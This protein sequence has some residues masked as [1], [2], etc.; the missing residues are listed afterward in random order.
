MAYD[1]DATEKNEEISVAKQY[2]VTNNQYFNEIYKEALETGL[3]DEKAH[4]KDNDYNYIY[5]CDDAYF[6]KIC[7]FGTMGAV[8]SNDRANAIPCY[9][10]VKNN[11]GL[12]SDKSLGKIKCN[13]DYELNNKNNT[14]IHDI[15]LNKNWQDLDKSIDKEI[16]SRNVSAKILKQDNAKNIKKE[17]KMLKL[18]AKK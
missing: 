10:F 11:L 4:L 3:K 18:Q 13:I 17:I 7:L 15:L 2:Y 16:K 9:Y 14:N 6:Q 8:E 5:N 12:L 1:F